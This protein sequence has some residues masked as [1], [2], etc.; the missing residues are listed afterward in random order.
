MS[1]HDLNQVKVRSR[2]L[3]AGN[4]PDLD[5]DSFSILFYNS[6]THSEHIPGHSRHQLQQEG[7]RYP[8]PGE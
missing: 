8:V 6:E 3:I 1:E 7:A 5:R 4:P 2:C